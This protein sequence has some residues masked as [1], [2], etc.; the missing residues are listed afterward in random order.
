MD[1]DCYRLDLKSDL[2][3]AEVDAGRYRRGDRGWSQLCHSCVICSRK[4]LPDESES[5][6]WNDKYLNTWALQVVG[7][8]W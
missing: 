3:K 2:E 8:T 7:E 5:F 6:L 4:N 1:S